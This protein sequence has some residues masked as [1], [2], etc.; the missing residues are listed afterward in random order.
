MKD[1]LLQ[2]SGCGYAG[3]EKARLSTCFPT[4]A[5]KPR[6]KSRL[7]FIRLLWVDL[8]YSYERHAPVTEVATPEPLMAQRLN[9]VQ[10][11]ESSP[12]GKCSLGQEGFHMWQLLIVHFTHICLCASTVF[13]WGRKQLFHIILQNPTYMMLANNI[14]THHVPQA[15]ACTLRT[16]TMTG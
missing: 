12:N 4:S 14:L 9:Q 7:T 6:L 10:M 11:L 2:N 13:M 3:G 5:K 8:D 15:Y 1:V 16:S